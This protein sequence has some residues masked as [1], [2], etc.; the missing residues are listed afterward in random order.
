M[1]NQKTF[2]EWDI[3]TLDEHGDIE[4]HNHSD[5]CPGFPSD[6]N[7]I[8]VLIRDTYEWPVN[9]PKRKCSPDLID[10]QWAYVE[11]RKLPK[12]FNG[13]AKIPIPFREELEKL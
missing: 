6:E 12:Q 7:K 4:D 5:K 10:R 11:N 2:Y 1:K 9:D 8:L 13:G 3:E